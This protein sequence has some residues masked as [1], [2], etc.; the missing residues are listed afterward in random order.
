[1]RIVV[2]NDFEAGGKFNRT[3][4]GIGE[5]TSF[6]ICSPDG[7]VS[8][9]T[10]SSSDGAGSSDEFGFR[11]TASSNGATT[12]TY[13]V[14]DLSESVVMSVVSPLAILG[15]KTGDQGY[16]AGEHGAGMTLDLIFTPLS[17][18]FEGV[19]VREEE[20]SCSLSG[21]FAG[22]RTPTSH[23]SSWTQLGSG[24]SIPDLAEHHGRDRQYWGPGSQTL[25]IQTHYRASNGGA[26]G[27][28]S[29]TQKQAMWNDQGT[30]QETKQ[31]AASAVRTP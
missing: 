19:E 13:T 11:W 21:S 6:S 16:P 25:G 5:P 31:G 9:G 23:N 1:M 2:T 29:T 28:I 14:G 8:V 27:T 10:W 4:V 17:V 24:N 30:A 18:S 12:I 3:T 20:V 22:G 15:S 26:S 7:D